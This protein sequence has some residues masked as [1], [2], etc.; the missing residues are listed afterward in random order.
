MPSA[1]TTFSYRSVREI[2]RALVLD[3]AERTWGADSTERIAAKWWLHKDFAHAIAAIDDQGGH[4]AGMVV[5]VPSTWPTLEGDTVAT[6][7]ICGW[8]VAPNYAGMGLGKRL[9]RYFDDVAPGQNALSIS[10]AAIRSFSALGWTGPWATRLMMLPLPGIR[11]S[12][13]QRDGFSLASH[14]VRQA[15]LPPELVDALD[16]IEATRPA[17]RIRRRRTASDW[18]AILSVW[19]ERTYHFHVA[20]RDGEPD[21]YFVIRATDAQAGSKYRLARLH[22]V[23]DI[24]TNS[25][26]PEALDFLASRVGPAAPLSAGVL[27]LCANDEAL[28]ARLA[29]HGWLSEHSRTIGPLLARKAPQFMLGGALADVPQTAAS[30]TFTDSDVDLNI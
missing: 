10:D 16:H 18:R 19:P 28:L 6:V 2:D 3:F 24:V 27:M 17:H 30:F 4:V 14:S 5:A 11:R 20:S 22:Y 15:S 23:S 1:D 12:P 26:A 7:S 9:V 25:D 13:R 8:F 21:G 29:G